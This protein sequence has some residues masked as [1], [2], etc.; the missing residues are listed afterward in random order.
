[1]Y[2]YYWVIFDYI[3]YCII[4]YKIFFSNRS[5]SCIITG[6]NT[7]S[8]CF[9]CRVLLCNPCYT[10]IETFCRFKGRNSLYLDLANFSTDRT[11]IKSKFINCFLIHIHDLVL[12]LRRFIFHVFWIGRIFNDFNFLQFLIIKFIVIEYYLVAF[13]KCIIQYLFAFGTDL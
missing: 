1:M 2:F 7:F 5:V 8:I 13:C 12:D 4:S 3:N 10:C 11:I 6:N 9:P